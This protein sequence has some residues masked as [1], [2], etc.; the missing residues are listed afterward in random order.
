LNPPMTVKIPFTSGSA[1]AA[2]RSVTRDSI[3]AESKSSRSSTCSPKVTRS[4][5]SANRASISWL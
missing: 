5:R 1:N 3:D 4:P 2:C